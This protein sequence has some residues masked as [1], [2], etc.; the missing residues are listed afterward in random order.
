VKLGAR[1]VEWWFLR[2]QLTLVLNQRINH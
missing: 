1:N 2:Q